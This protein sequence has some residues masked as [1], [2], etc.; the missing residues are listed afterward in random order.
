MSDA[1]AHKPNHPYHL[2]NPSPWPLV[3]SLAGG[4]FAIGM[5]FYMHGKASFALAVLPGIALILLTMFGWW[6]D[7]IKEAQVDKAHTP[8]VQIG[9]RYGMALFIAS[10]VMFFVAFFWAFFDSSLFP[11]EAIGGVW[12]PQGMAVLDPLQIPL[13]NTLILL[14]SGCTVT[15]A[16]HALREGDR[17]SFIQGLS[18]TVGLGLIFTGFQAYEYA[19]APFGFKDGIYSST[20]YMATGFHGFHVLVGTLFLIVCLFRG[21]KGHFTPD[22]HFGFE[23]AAWYWHF[24]DVVWLFLFFFIYIWGSG[25]GP[26]HG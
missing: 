15:W 8:V 4:V 23:A 7:I 19:H 21:L 3:G 5:V 17:K 2:V 10:E 22:H 24:V 14:L 18:L 9:L 11:K 13:L 20:F 1:A 12:P 26:Y 25:P 16:H 6:R